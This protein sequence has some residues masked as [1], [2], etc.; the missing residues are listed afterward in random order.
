MYKIVH[1][2]YNFAE[3]KDVQNIITRYEIKKLED[4]SKIRTYV[5]AN[6]LEAPN[7]SELGRQLG[8]DRRTIKKYYEGYKKTNQRN[9]KSKIDN[10]YDLI[11]NLLSGE[12]KQKFYYKS[13]LYRY[14]VREHGLECKQNT[15]SRYILKHEKFKEY[16][17]GKVINKS[18]KSETPFGYQGQF[19]WKEDIKFTFK[20]GETISFDVACFVLSASRFKVWTIYPNRSRSCVMDFL[21]R[22]FELIGGVPKEIYVDNAKSIMDT[23]RTKNDLGKINIEL[24]AMSND[25]GFNIKP[26]MSYRPQTKAK[27]ESPMRLVDEIMNYNGLLKDYMELHEKISM[28]V[29]EANLRV[30]QA[31]NLPPIFVLEKEKEHLLSL[32]PDKICSRYKI[33]TKMLKVNKNSLISHHQAKYSVPSCFIN[34]YLSIKEIDNKLYVYDNRNIVS[35]HP[36]SKFNTTNYLESHSIQLHSETFKNKKSIQLQALEN[37]KELEKFNEQISKATREF[38]QIE[39]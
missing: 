13:H 34:K 25:Y 15:F 12:N 29:N 30:C 10:Y 33:K 22:T 18:I 4:I 19:D 24:Q 32:P 1:R 21:A 2:Y 8:A 14:L 16:F 39:T 17:E 27:V 26:C 6:K 31:T 3:V 38:R 37:L 20:N 36:I 23:A 11:N 9:R 5:E 7:F 35:I 28:L